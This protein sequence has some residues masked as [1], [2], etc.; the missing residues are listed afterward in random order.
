MFRNNKGGYPDER[1]YRGHSVGTFLL[2]CG[3]SRSFWEESFL[4]LKT[5]AAR[6]A[7][8]HQDGVG[9]R[10]RA[11]RGAEEQRQIQRRVIFAPKP[12][13]ERGVFIYHLKSCTA[14]ILLLAKS[15]HGI[16]HAGNLS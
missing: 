1:S 12:R 7:A 6:R 4:A 5:P 2:P 10:C 9:S 13:A 15:F 8:R 11:E 3:A 16:D 14:E